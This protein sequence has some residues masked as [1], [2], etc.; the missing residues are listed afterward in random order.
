MEIYNKMKG[1]EMLSKKEILSHPLFHVPKGSY[2]FGFKTKVKCKRFF[3]D[4]H[5]GELR[6]SFGYSLE[7]NEKGVLKHIT[8]LETEKDFLDDFTLEYVSSYLLNISNLYE[9]KEEALEC[10]ATIV[11]VLRN[12]SKDILNKKGKE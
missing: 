4:I 10:N 1:E 7:E 3:L 8:C 9:E 5:S 12:I 11:E 6:C 2:C